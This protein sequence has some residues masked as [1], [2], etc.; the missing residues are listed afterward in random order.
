M[1]DNIKKVADIAMLYDFYGELLTEH[2]KRVFE[3][4]YDEDLSL[5]E[6]GAEFGISRQAVH[7]LLQRCEGILNHY[8]EILGWVKRY[9]EEQAT[10]E[11]LTAIVKR[12]ESGE[13]LWPEFWQIWQT[14]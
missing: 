11:Q 14:L 9:R 10:K 8:E 4:F 6:I 5:A 12:I 2:Q 1:A 3:L 13:D 7:D